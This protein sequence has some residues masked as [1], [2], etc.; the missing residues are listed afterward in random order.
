MKKLF[1]N[2]KNIIILAIFLIFLA[3]LGGGSFIDL[4]HNS[5]TIRK[6]SKKSALLDKQYQDLT[7]EYQEILDGKTNYIED[8]ARVKYH[9]AKPGEIEFRIKK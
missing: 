4:I 8:N 7:K 6:L 5:F 2:K 9:M 1:K 3:I